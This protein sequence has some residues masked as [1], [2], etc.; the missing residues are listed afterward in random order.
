MLLQIKHKIVYNIFYYNILLQEIILLVQN[1]VL[2]IQF[3]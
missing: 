3:Y 2:L 1:D